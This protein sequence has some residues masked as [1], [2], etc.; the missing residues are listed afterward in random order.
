MRNVYILGDTHKINIV[1]LLE[2]H[3]LKNFL[4]IGVGDHGEIGTKHEC[5]HDIKLVADY[6]NENNGRVL[7]TRGNHSDPTWFNFDHWANDFINVTY[8]PDNIIHTISGKKVYFSGGAVSVDRKLNTL[9]IDY[10]ANEAFNPVIPKEPIDI[11]ITHTSHISNG[12]SRIAHF[13]EKDETLRQDL[14]NE[15]NLMRHFVEKVNPKIA[16]FWGHFHFPYVDYSNNRLERCLDI[17]EIYD[18]SH[19]FQ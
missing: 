17:D 16:H 14:I 18:A 8:V 12:F 1:P 2:R 3:E 10:F 19:L 9:G 11:L 15:Q 13:F 7:F 5:Q 6:C 4:L